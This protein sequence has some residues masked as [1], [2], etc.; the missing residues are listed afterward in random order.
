[1][2]EVYLAIE[3][4]QLRPKEN[5]FEFW[6]TKQMY[7]GSKFHGGST[8]FIS[9]NKM[10]LQS[11]NCPELTA[12]GRVLYVQG[13]DYTK[14]DI[15][16]TATPSQMLNIEFAIAEYNAAVASLE[17][18]IVY[19]PKK[20]LIC[21]AATF[22]TLIELESLGYNTFQFRAY[23]KR[24]ESAFSK[25]LFDYVVFVCMGEA[26]HA[27]G[28]TN[29]ACYFPE[30]ARL[31][32]N[33]CGD[34]KRNMVY[35]KAIDYEPMHALEQMARAFNE[36]EWAD[37]SYG[38]K[39]WGLL[40]TTGLKY[41]VVSNRVFIDSIV[42]LQHNSGTIFSKPIFFR[43][44]LADGMGYDKH[45]KCIW[46][47]GS[48]LEDKAKA[49]SDPIKVACDLSIAIS[50]ECWS[51][52]KDAKDIGMIK[53]DPLPDPIKICLDNNIEYGSKKLEMVVSEKTYAPVSDEDEDVDEDDDYDKNEDF[54]PDPNCDCP[55][56]IAYYKKQNKAKEMIG[57]L[58]KVIGITVTPNSTNSLYFTFG[59]TIAPTKWTMVDEKWAPPEITKVI[60]QVKK[61]KQ[62]VTF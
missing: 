27:G 56:C 16:L 43:D 50:E 53:T 54:E 7:I 52:V 8:A 21:L 15:V 45:G 39:K 22:Y 18:S 10:M 14:N 30:L 24:F 23:T 59:S 47:L 38:G 28:Q 19:S 41:G 62:D 51:F 44:E 55:Q 42:H 33:Q 31:G 25:M 20:R 36:A 2:D 12:N 13:S 26:R 61:E 40:A 34:D 1:M 48:Y 57:A 9:T 58:E 3:K 60:E 11:C 6:I 5:R 29:G 17:K 32:S 49:G 35:I 37:F 46:R 4:K